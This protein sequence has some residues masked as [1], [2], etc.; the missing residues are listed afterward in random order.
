M[1]IGMSQNFNSATKPITKA[2]T[3]ENDLIDTF[4]HHHDLSSKINKGPCNHLT[5]TTTTIHTHKH[6]PKIHITITHHVT[7]DINNIQQSTP[8][9]GPDKIYIGNGRGLQILSTG[10]TTIHK[11]SHS[12]KLNHIFHV[13]DIK[14]NLLSVKKF[15]KDN[16]IF[17]EFH[18]EFCAVKDHVTHQTLL[19][20][21]NEKGI[22]KWMTS[23]TPLAFIRERTSPTKWHDR[24]GHPHFGTLLKILNK[25][26][27][28][29]THKPL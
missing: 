18:P 2:L 8:Y 10:S 29:T 6:T 25:Y 4:N 23:P 11:N 12:L 21:G 14:K 15:V 26:G 27:L 24:L 5:T 7:A 13:L 19:N 22:Y 20:R 17:C 1:A 9:T 16:N 3:I 28:P